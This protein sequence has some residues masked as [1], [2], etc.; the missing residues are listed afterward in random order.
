MKC[1]GCLK[2]SKDINSIKCCGAACDK[3]FCSMCINIG[4]MSNEKKKNWRCPDC[5]A[6]KKKGGDN[7][8]TPVRPADENITL[9]K[10]HDESPEENLHAE[11][12]E[13][14]EEVRLLTREITSLKER[15][16]SATSSM[17][18]C[19]ARLEELTTSIATNDFRI[20]SL[21][22]RDKEV[23]I[24]E[25]KVLELQQEVN[26]QSQQQLCNELELAGIPESNN[27]NL[28]H[29]ALLAAKKVGVDLADD[30]IDWVTRAGPHIKR[31]VNPN[32]DVN[33]T[34]PIV[35]R[36]L[37]RSKRD[38]LIKASKTR[39]NVTSSDLD[40]PGKS[41]KIYYN[42][43]LTKENRL[44]FR[45]A[46]SKAKEHQYAY[47][48]VTHGKIFLKQKEGKAALHVRTFNDLTRIFCTP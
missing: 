48:W 34:R 45:T 32:S 23:K 47:C 11:V 4:T 44:L 14:T 38:Q 26:T 17:S 41:Y 30:D 24:L 25:N 18:C 10:K 6:M 33:S 42:E 1:S 20:K 13:L 43:R 27:E 39:R 31:A 36:F 2:A 15:L 37:R 9:R 35:V 19:Q 3:Q 46:R 40:V 8:L 28:H 22:N 29:I 7:S 5:C 12:K 16:E 21:E